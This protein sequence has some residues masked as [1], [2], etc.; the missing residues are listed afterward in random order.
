[1]VC[2]DSL[3]RNVSLTLMG[4]HDYHMGLAFHALG[5]AYSLINLLE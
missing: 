1:M 3:T 4:M 5:L 2:L